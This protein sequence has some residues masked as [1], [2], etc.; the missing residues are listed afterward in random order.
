MAH[1]TG[2]TAARPILSLEDLLVRPITRT[3]RLFDITAALTGIIVLGPLMALIALTV[4]ITCGRPI[5]FCHER[6]GI[7]RRRFWM[8]KFR[9]MVP[10]AIHRSDDLRYLNEMTGP[11]F[12]IRNDPRLTWV[13][14]W[15]RRMSLD[16]LPQLFNVLRGE[17]TLIGPRALSPRPEEYEPWQRRRFS[18][19]PGIACTWQAD[20]RAKRDFL[21]WMRSDLRHIDHASEGGDLRLMFRV[22]RRVILCRGAY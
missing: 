22:L 8:F 17:M 13:G 5:L 21:A 10:D 9:T 4:L 15:L 20:H 2:I 12:K 16:E 7:G 18:V 11:L 1:S 3:R 14:H 19:T 6:T